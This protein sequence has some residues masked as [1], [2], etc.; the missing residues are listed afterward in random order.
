MKSEHL[1]RQYFHQKSFLTEKVGNG[2]GLEPFFFPHTVHRVV[3]SD[4]LQSVAGF[5]A[6]AC[7]MGQGQS[8]IG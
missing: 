5:H 8:L 2:T 6:R 1:L 4:T 3:V 7:M